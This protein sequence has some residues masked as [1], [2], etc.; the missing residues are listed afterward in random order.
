MTDITG[1]AAVVT[2]GGT[3]IG[4]GLAKELARSGVKVAIADIM[5]DNARRTAAEIVAEGGQ[6][7]AIACDV[8]ERGAI[9]AM[10]EVAEAAFGPIQLLFANAGATCFDR[11][12]D[13]TDDSVDWIVQVNMMGVLNTVRAFLP[14]MIAAGGGHVVATSS[15]AGLMPGSIPVHCVYAGAKMGII[16]LMTNLAMEVERHGIRITTYCPGGVSTGMGERNSSYRPPRFGGPSDAPLQVPEE[17]FQDNHVPFYSPESV[18]PI[19]LEAVRRNRPFV[20]DHAEQRETF[21]ETYSRVIE[22]CFDD[23]ERWET[24]HGT[25]EVVGAAG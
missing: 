25:P 24:E 15:V 18:A 12:E 11:L 20:F 6:A 13:M 2:G 21:R 1:K 5:I 16:G 22:A 3:G 19:V 7:I 10:R 9:R 4:M 8:C 14:G 23:I 17:S